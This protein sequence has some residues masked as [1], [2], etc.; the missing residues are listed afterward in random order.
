MSIRVYRLLSLSLFI[1]T[2]IASIL[3]RM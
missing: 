3:V 2:V 1:L